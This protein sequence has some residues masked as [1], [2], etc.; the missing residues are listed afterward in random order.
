MIAILFKFIGPGASA[1]TKGL[2]QQLSGTRG[3]V[4][5]SRASAGNWHKYP[6]PGMKTGTAVWVDVEFK[7]DEFLNHML[8]MANK[9]INFTSIMNNICVFLESRIK[10]RI[11][12]T[13]RNTPRGTRVGGGVAATGRL[14]SDWTHVLEQ[15]GKDL[16]GR[17]GTMVHYA[18]LHEFGGTVK[19]KRS[20]ALTIPFPG[21]VGMYPPAK[22]LMKTGQTYIRKNIIFYK[23]KGVGT[24]GVKGFRGGIPIYILKKSVNIPARP[25]LRWV[26]TV[27]G[28]RIGDAFGKHL[29]MAIHTP[30]TTPNV[31]I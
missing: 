12:A 27:Y 14:S 16:V 10:E 2:T 11:R 24:K 5:F 21:N 28:P 18:R 15:Q 19:P 9:A 7:L 17:V 22:D 30:G 20:H 3:G 6:V 23:P 29:E 31:V 4:D 25:Y 1:I 8:A 13:L 26:L